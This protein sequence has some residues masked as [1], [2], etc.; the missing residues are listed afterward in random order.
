LANH[1]AQRENL[2]L[3]HDNVNFDIYFIR[4]GESQSNITPG[5]AAGKNFDAPMTD[6]GHQQAQ[7][8]GCRLATEDVTFDR[9]YSSTLIRAV[10]TTEGMLRGMGITG[11]GFDRV[12]P[13]IERQIPA[14][15]GRLASEVHTPEVKLLEA[16]KGKW[17]QPADGESERLVE[18]RA[19]NWLE[20]EITYN[21]QWLKKK[22]SHRIAVVS[23]GI[24]LRCLIH[25]ITGMDQSFLKRT[26]IYN[27]SISRF[28]FG[29]HGWSIETIND[30]SHTLEVGDIVR[31]EGIIQG[32]TITP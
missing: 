20:D 6:R 15:R 24:T 31:D 10:Q 4:H 12:E 2:Y 8:L 28:K 29:K 26:Q 30:A 19:S 17:F 11:V 32:D 23:H 22:G 9:I 3:I 13:I 18:R 16:G 25:Y 1:F 7:A 5:I 21:P 27:T 14:W